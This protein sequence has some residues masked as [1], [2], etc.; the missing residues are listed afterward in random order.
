[1]TNSSRKQL[2]QGLMSRVK[3]CLLCLGFI[4]SISETDA[5]FNV[6]KQMDM[7]ALVFPRVDSGLKRDKREWVIPAINILE[8]DRGPFPKTIVKIESSRIKEI[9]V[10]Y[11]I[12]GQGADQAPV[13]IFVIERNTGSLNVTEPL[14]REEKDSYL[15]MAY[16]VSADGENV[17]EPIEIK[18]IV[19]DANDNRPYFTQ[20]SFTGSVAENVAPGTSVMTVT[21]ADADDPNTYNA[22]L[23]YFLLDKSPD[24]MFTIN[25]ETG[26]I[27]TVAAGL[28]R[29]TVD[30]YI[31][32]IKVVD[33]E[34]NG[35][36]A[37]GT[38]TILIT[39]TNDNAP[40]FR[41]SQY[42]GSVAEDLV[43]AVITRLDVIDKDQERSPNWNAVYNI[44]GGNE[45]GL[46]SVTTD[47]NTNECILQTAKGL[48]FETNAEHI[49]SIT[50]INEESFSVTLHTSTAT[51][52]ITVFDENEAPIFEPLEKIVSIREDR[53]VGSAV[54]TYTARD[55]DTHQTQIIQY[56][57]GSDPLG[58]LEC[59]P[60]GNIHTKLELDREL[61]PMEN[62]KYKATIL[63]YD[64]VK[65]PAV[66]VQLVFFLS[67]HSVCI[68]GFLFVC[69]LVLQCLHMVDGKSA[70]P[71]L[72]VSHELNERM[73]EK[74]NNI[75]KCHENPLLIMSF[76]QGT[77][78]QQQDTGELETFLKSLEI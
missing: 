21:A 20:A 49:L 53:P 42:T 26:L 61:L 5:S 41:H 11:S 52:T 19:T 12:T 57:I 29:E 66:V 10:Y 50:A 58:W 36:E 2:Y 56:L 31:L 75:T 60:D 38:A 67:G 72:D 35:Y 54:Y 15:L 39:D 44:T 76:E 28:D 64:N 8:N 47:T 37:T 77:S 9:K 30:Q 59:D 65:I 27:S 33:Y 62:N 51:V 4:L 17:E 45:N 63:A 43:G 71:V 34:G 48:D 13:G 69:W 14:D 23:N 22:I 24:M 70:S 1:M 32:H 6:Q 73:R 18:I 40:Q 55:P 3:G 25:R 7:P 16:A 68:G 46:F 78:T 74:W